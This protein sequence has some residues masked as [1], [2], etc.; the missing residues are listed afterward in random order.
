VVVDG[1]EV[2]CRLL[3]IAENLHR[4]ELTAIERAE[5]IAER[6]RLTTRGVPRQ[7]DAK[8]Q[9]G[10]GNTGGINS[11]TREQFSFRTPSHIFVGDSSRSRKLVSG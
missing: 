6:I 1:D 4:A 7:L 2:E 11:A 10:R 8:P 3:E 9:G 5:H